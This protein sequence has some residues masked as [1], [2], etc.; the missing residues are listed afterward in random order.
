MDKQILNLSYTSSLSNLCE[1]NPSFDAGILKI[2]YPG[3]NHNGSYISKDD[4]ERCIKTIYNCPIVCNYDR[5]SDTLGGHDMDVV[6][7]SAR[8]LTLVNLTTPIGVVPE[9]AKIF[10][11]KVEEEDG[12]IREYLCA[13]VLLWKRQEAYEKVRRDGIV[14]QSM[15]IAVQDGEVMADGLYHI[16]DFK[17]LAFALIGVRP[18][19]ESASLELFSEQAFKSQFSQMMSELKEYFNLVN[20]SKEDDITKENDLT[21]GGKRMADNNFAL[22]ENFLN[23]LRQALRSETFRTDDGYEYSRYWYVDCDTD[24]QEVYAFDMNEDILYGFSYKTNGDNVVIDFDSKKRKKYAIVDFDEGEQSSFTGFDFSEL[25]QLIH[26]NFEWQSKYD[27]VSNRVEDMENELDELRGYKN[28]TEADKLF[29]QFKDLNGVEAFEN[30][31]AA[32]E[33]Y[34]MET[35]EEKCYAIR[36]RQGAGTNLKFEAK[37]P[38]ISVE[39]NKNDDEPYG[40]LF[41][42]YGF[43]NN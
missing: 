12:T 32:Y 28:E 26:D 17:F 29:S 3:A 31:R 22:T 21:K 11:D 15:E 7:N 10:W 37:V 20:A 30:L 13:E 9:S 25:K 33:D 40:G 16:R 4:F 5:E 18:C 8:G 42:K 41:R 39:N 34:D 19:F 36:G 27:N 24:V 43:R 23:E 35:L 1:I 14:A 2:A 6:N 38:K